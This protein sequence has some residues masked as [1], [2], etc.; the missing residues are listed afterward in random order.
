M[1]V[2][3][4]PLKDVFNQF[5]HQNLIRIH[6]SHAVNIDYVETIKGNVVIVGGEEVPMSGDFKEKAL[7][8]FNIIR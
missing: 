5:N 8:Q 2:L 7:A 6:R 1:L 4:S 3:S